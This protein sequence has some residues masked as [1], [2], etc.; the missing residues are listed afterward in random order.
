MTPLPSSPVSRGTERS[1]SPKCVLPAGAS[2][3]SPT[4]RRSSVGSTGGSALSGAPTSG[5][6]PD[7]RVSVRSEV[8]A[9]SAVDSRLRRRPSQ[10][11]SSSRCGSVVRASSLPTPA[12]RKEPPKQRG[13][14]RKGRLEQLIAEISSLFARNDDGLK[15]TNTRLAETAQLEL[16]AEEL[17]WLIGEHKEHQVPKRDMSVMR[18]DKDLRWV[19]QQLKRSEHEHQHLLSRLAC[20][21][22]GT[23]QQ[24]LAELRSIEEEIESEKKRQKNLVS[25]NRLREKSLVRNAVDGHEI[26]PNERAQKQIDQFEAEVSVLKVKNASL[27]KQIQEAKELLQKAQESCQIFEAKMGLVNDVLKSEQHAVRQA[28]DSQA[29]QQIRDEEKRLRDEIEE[30]KGARRQAAKSSERHRRERSREQAEL[31]ERRTVLEAKEAKLEAAERILRRQ[32]K[33]K[34]RQQRARAHRS[35]S[36]SDVTTE[37]A[38]AH[39]ASP[40]P[41]PRR[42]VSGSSPAQPSRSPPTSPD[43]NGSPSPDPAANRKESIVPSPQS[44]LRE[45]ML[46]PDTLCP[47]SDPC[48]HC[49]ATV[50]DP[51]PEMQHQHHDEEDLSQACCDAEEAGGRL[52]EQRSAA[53]EIQRIVRGRQTRRRRPEVPQ[54]HAITVQDTPVSPTSVVSILHEER[55]RWMFKEDEECRHPPLPATV[56]ATESPLSV[57][58][59][60]CAPL[61]AAPASPTQTG[62]RESSVDARLAADPDAVQANDKKQLQSG[63]P[64]DGGQQGPLPVVSRGRRPSRGLEGKPQQSGTAARKPSRGAEARQPSQAPAK[65]QPSRDE[66]RQQ[67]QRKPRSPSGGPKV[68]PQDVE[69]AR[70][71]VGP[72]KQRPSSVE[73]KTRPHETA[74]QAQAHKSSERN[75]RQSRGAKARVPSQGPRP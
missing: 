62:A 2:R 58:E 48:E 25:E 11:R 51:Q 55:P 23:R 24:Q 47:E 38:E 74:L 65:R 29:Q 19:R 75:S 66:A 18:G 44:E 40:P 37:H 10:D 60:R 68:R 41:K 73:P 54:T 21:D 59:A 52:L 31:V 50:A 43:A 34:R 53:V 36:R 70:R 13:P 1:G 28:E 49:T 16:Y 26:D 14:P 3:S 63:V 72:A 27:Q 39:P 20:L 17:R 33:Q 71:L 64:S 69:R 9:V 57:A 32:L 61:E 4:D 22:P 7:G 45:E 6:E 35:P 15:D 46:P 30:L 12:S 8:S 42:S 5:T 56:V 67:P